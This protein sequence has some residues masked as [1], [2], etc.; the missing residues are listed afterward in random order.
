MVVKDIGP[1]PKGYKK[2]RLYSNYSNL[3][4]AIFFGQG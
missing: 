4:Y 2:Q 1:P 3:S